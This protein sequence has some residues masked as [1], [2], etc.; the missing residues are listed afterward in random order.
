MKKLYAIIFTLVTISVL[1]QKK[2]QHPW[3]VKVATNIVDSSGEAGVNPFKNFETAAFGGTPLQL[4]LEYRLNNLLGVELAYSFNEWDSAKGRIDNRILTKNEKYVSTD[5][6]LK[7][8]FS[9]HIDF[10]NKDWFEIY[11]SAGVGYFNISFGEYNLNLG[12]GFNI[13]FSKSLGLNY[14]TTLKTSYEQ[15]LSSFDTNHLQYSFGFMYRFGSSNKK[16]NKI[17][18]ITKKILP[19]EEAKEPEIQQPTIIDTD[20]DGVIDAADNCP[21][22][23]GEASNNGC[24]LPDVDGDGITD[25]L[26]KCPLIAGVK[27]LDGCKEEIKPIDQASLNEIISM[28]VKIKFKPGNYNF[29]QDSY[30]VLYKIAEILKEHPEANFRIEGHTDSV[31]SYQTNRRL[32]KNRANAVKAYLIDFGISADRITAV[33]IGELKPIATNLYKAGREKNRRVEII[34]EN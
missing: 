29:T 11:L 12:G 19:K 5:L 24:P 9:N 28:S 2:V 15:S 21:R 14:Q 18:E 4:G 22:I 17:Q 8:Y 30:D 26:D 25:A 32:S 13:W 3:Q 27:E 1:G 7:Y 20:N 23:F 16:K 6:N 33:G 10:L 34:L 31:G